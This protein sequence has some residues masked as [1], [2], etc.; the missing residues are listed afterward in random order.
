MRL[1]AQDEVIAAFLRKYDAIPEGDRATLPWEA[2]AIAADVN[3]SHLLGSAMI[4]LSVYSANA[5]RIIAVTNHPRITQKRVEYGLLPS[6]EKDRNALDIM[7]GAMPSAKGPT[8]IG[9][10]F[11]GG[12][13]ADGGITKDKDDESGET[14]EPTAVFGVDDDLDNLF[15]PA[16]TMQEKL[17]PIRQRLLEK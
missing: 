11:F 14:A 2:I 4:A 17:V 8:F 3:V 5:S 1:S 13:G 15:P 9:K 16:N 12:G 7:V 6:G 10:A